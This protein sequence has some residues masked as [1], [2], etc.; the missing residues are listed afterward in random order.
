MNRDALYSDGTLT[1]V[2]PA[3]PRYYED[4]MVRLRTARGDAK[5]CYI[6][7]KETRTEMKKESS[8]AY[9]DYYVGKVFVKDRPLKYSFYVENGSEFLYY[10]HDGAGNKIP[11][12][13][14]VLVPG[15]YT[16]DWAEGAVMYQIFLDRFYNGDPTNDVRTNE[17]HYLGE[18]VSHVS[19]WNR[20]IKS[21]DVR[22]F[23]GGDLAGVLQKLDY[24]SGLGVEAIYFNPVFVSPSN[25]KYDTQDYDAVD[26]HLGVIVSDYGNVLGADSTDNSLAT[27]YQ[28]RTVLHENL[29]ASNALLAKV[30]DAAHKRGIKV[31]LD[32]VFNHCGSFNKWLDREGFYAGKDAYAPGAYKEK[33]SP[34]R[35]F[36]Y[37][38]Q[39]DWPDNASYEGWWGMDTLPKLAY[40][41]SPNLQRYILHVAQKWVSPPY[42]AD[43]WRLDVAADL[44][45]SPGFNH[46]FWKMFR[47]AVHEANPEA[48]VLAEHYGDPESW[49]HDGS[50]DTIMNYDA[51]ME[52]VSYFFTGMEKHSDS[53]KEGLHGSA[54]HFFATIKQ[55][56]SRMPYPAIFT[57]MNQLS[58]HDHSRFLTRTNHKVGRLK[59]LGSRAAEEGVLKCVMRLAVLLQMTWPGAPTIYYGDEAGVC[60]FTDPDS[61]RPYPWGREDKEMIAFHRDMIWIRRNYQSLKR[62]SLKM[63]HAEGPVL[64]YGRFLGGERVVVIINGDGALRK[65]EVPV[66]MSE[67]PEGQLLRL[68]YT[69]EAGYTKEA[70][71][72]YVKEGKVQLYMGAYSAVVLKSEE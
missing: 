26:P 19:D 58:N 20:D 47:K 63:L 38:Y 33:D 44:G 50:W 67:V 22:E 35:D 57:S 32:G 68:M 43:G 1:F 5:R 34:Y 14:F 40:E 55:S 41:N 69:Y 48:L 4:V 28:A 18:K 9:F 17:Y 16:P 13:P 62:G 52:P 53:Y 71:T 54:E 42:N 10:G 7:T 60:G 70:D 27:K 36:F 2:S 65:V 11:G 12:C 3:K 6:V 15:L 46:E 23:Y 29:E 49:L 64:A 31:I 21:M 8:N 39:D 37:F 51:F 59:A 66:W 56:V 61:R 25:H 72:L 45:K 24:L 30:I